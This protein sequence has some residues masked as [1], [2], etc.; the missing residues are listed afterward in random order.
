M[1]VVSNCTFSGPAIEYELRKHDVLGF[2]KFVVSSADYG[3]RKPHPLIF[4]TSAAKIG[5]DPKDI[6]FIGDS[7]KNDVL[8]SSAC[9]MQPVWFNP[10]GADAETSAVGIEIRAYT[11]LIGILRACRRARLR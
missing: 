11:D 5:A 7:L 3:I 9:G 4:E 6:W 2:F 10:K 8:G 1:G